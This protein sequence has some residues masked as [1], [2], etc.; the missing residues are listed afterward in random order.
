MNFADH[1]KLDFSRGQ[2]IER[3]Y[4]IIGTMPQQKDV[5]YK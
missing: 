2:N 3:Q 5:L 4:M 1:F